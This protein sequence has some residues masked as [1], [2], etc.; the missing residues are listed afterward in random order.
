MF[1]FTKSNSSSISSQWK[2]LPL[3]KKNTK[4]KVVVSGIKDLLFSTR[5]MEVEVVAVEIFTT[6][7]R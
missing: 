2:A 3:V 7:N 5:V 4:R 1:I 6:F